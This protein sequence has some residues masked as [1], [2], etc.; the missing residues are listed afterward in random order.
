MKINYNI[1]VGKD[2]ANRFLQFVMFH[3]MY[4]SKTALTIEVCTTNLLSACHV[5]HAHD[6]AAK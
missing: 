2:G 1:A 4:S 3:M 6:Y 5:D